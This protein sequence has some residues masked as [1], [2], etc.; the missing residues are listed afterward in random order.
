MSLSLLYRQY[1]HDHDAFAGV[2]RSTYSALSPV[3]RVY[4]ARSGLTPC[5]RD[6]RASCH[7]A[8]LSNLSPDTIA[9]VAR[10]SLSCYPVTRGPPAMTDDLRAYQ[11]MQ[12]RRRHPIPSAQGR[13]WRR[14]VPLVTPGPTA[15]RWTC[16]A[17]GRVHLGGLPRWVACGH[18]RLRPVPTS[19]P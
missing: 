9:G 10:L 11:A 6:R 1:R 18:V 19:V 3:R 16:T 17:C 7:V 14:P 8:T 15:G 4:R 12:Y 2:C 13:T 5:S